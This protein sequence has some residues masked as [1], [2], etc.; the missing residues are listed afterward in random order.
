VALDCSGERGVSFDDAPAEVVHDHGLLWLRGERGAL[1]SLGVK[2]ATVPH[3]FPSE[4]V[5][6]VL[7][8]RRGT[9]WVL[10]YDP[11]PEDIRVWE[12]TSVGWTP[13]VQMGAPAEQMLALSELDDQPLLVSTRALYV[14]GDDGLARGKPLARPIERAL[15]YSAIMTAD[16]KL[17][18]GVDRGEL[19]GS[20]LRI[21]PY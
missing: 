15:S 17:W 2:R 11:V 13:R 9:L 16:D 14:A 12:R 1:A 20:L 21:D 5:V 3:H 19:G 10:T 6:D 8:T 4:V 18:I 7:S